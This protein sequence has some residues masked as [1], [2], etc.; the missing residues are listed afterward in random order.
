MNENKEIRIEI[1]EFITH[2]NKSKFKY[3]KINGQAIYSGN[4]HPRTRALVVETM[5][6]YLKKYLPKTIDLT[7]MYPI[8]VAL[9]FHVPVNYGDVSLRTDKETGK[10]KLCWKETHIGYMPGWDVDNQWIWGKCFNDVL[11]EQGIIP[12]DNCMY[13]R[14]SGEVT[15]KEV[16][17][18]NDRKLVF[19]IKQYKHE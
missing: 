19:I 2:V 1:P 12:D 16:S 5:H 11:K 4:L 8:K 14:S 17:H 9:E 10:K 15:W 3:F 18:I 7:G 13:V 6:N